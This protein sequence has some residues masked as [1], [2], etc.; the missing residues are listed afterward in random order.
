MTPSPDTIRAARK[1]VQDLAEVTVRSD[2]KRATKA[3]VETYVQQLVLDLPIGAFTLRSLADVRFST[4]PPITALRDRLS[5]WWAANQSQH[6][7]ADPVHGGTDAYSRLSATDRLWVDYWRLRSGE[8]LTDEQREHVA[9]LVRT[10]S[11][12]AWQHVTR[13]ASEPPPPDLMPW[14][15]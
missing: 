7:A 14:N 13:A 1:W 12:D 11:P 9:S 8:G 15:S 3:Q 2:G 4:W 6:R 5:A 10:Q